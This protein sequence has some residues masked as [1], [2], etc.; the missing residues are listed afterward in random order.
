MEETTIKPKDHTDTFSI[1]LF[2][3]HKNREASKLVRAEQYFLKL[4]NSIPSQNIFA[5]GNVLLLN[6]DVHL[7]S[8][9][10]KNC[11]EEITSRKILLN[12]FFFF[13]EEQL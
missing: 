2:I 6:H 11:V 12:L 10:N 1:L 4:F 3:E 8:E 9:I 5:R 7:D 13:N